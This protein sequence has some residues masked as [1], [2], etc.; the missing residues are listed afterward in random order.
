MDYG[1]PVGREV[2]PPSVPPS[3]LEEVA[4]RV[5]EAVVRGDFERACGL[6][7]EAARVGHGVQKKGDPS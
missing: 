1:A 6:I 5:R 4:K 7:D 3:F 2:R